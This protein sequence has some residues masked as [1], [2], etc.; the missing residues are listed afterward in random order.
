[1]PTICSTLP[2]HVP[3]ECTT[4]SM[5]ET[6]DC[7]VDYLSS[8]FGWT[9][10]FVS[11]F[12]FFFSLLFPIAVARTGWPKSF[13][14]HG[15]EGWRGGEVCVGTS[16]CLLRNPF[17]PGCPPKAQTRLDSVNLLLSSTPEPAHIHTHTH[18]QRAT[19]RAIP[20]PAMSQLTLFLS[21]SLF[22]SRSRSRS[23]SHS[24]SHSYSHSPAL[25]HT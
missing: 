13:K 23:H 17:L 14:V 20:R 21:L 5:K 16:P 1:M 8:Y 11:F 10:F 6:S 4:D 2:S 19:S 15:W 18:T 7:L 9:F 12:L 3:V 25:S 22:L 24:H